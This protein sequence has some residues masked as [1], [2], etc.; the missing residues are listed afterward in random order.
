M[1]S[2]RNKSIIANT[3]TNHLRN[4]I[5]CSIVKRIMK[6]VKCILRKAS[7]HC[8]VDRY[9]TNMI[10]HLSYDNASENSL[11]SIFSFHYITTGAIYFMFHSLCFDFIKSNQGKFISFYRY[12]I[13]QQNSNKT[14]FQRRKAS[15][16]GDKNI[17][18][19]CCAFH[20]WF[21]FMWHNK[22]ARDR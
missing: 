11:L 22:N 17:N 1:I 21:L 18:S 5:S 10:F 19:L 4:N 3:K 2:L 20:K 16:V 12:A 6:S 7:P 13:E 8:V 9:F 14:L 15:D